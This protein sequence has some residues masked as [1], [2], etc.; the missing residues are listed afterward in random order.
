MNGRAITAEGI[1][2]RYGR[3]RVLDALDINVAQGEFVSLLGPSGSGKTTFLMVLAGFVMPEAGRLLFGSESVITK[4][5]HRRNL[6]MVF[7]SHALFPHLSVFENVAFPLRIRQ[8]GSEEIRRRVGDALALVRLEELAERRVTQLSGGQSQRVALARAIVFEPQILLMDEPLSALDKQLREHMQMEIRAL[9]EQIGLTTVYVTHDQREAFA[10]SDRVAILDRGRIVQ[11]DTP[12]RL[13]G[14]PANAFVAGFVGESSFLPVS[15][16]S[17]EPF[18]A[19]K[20]LR[21][22]RK[23]APESATL[24]MRPE[25]LILGPAT[26]A[27]DGMNH[28]PGIVER[29]VFQGDSM[30]VH[31]SLDAGVEVLVRKAIRR[32][33]SAR[34]MHAGERVD[35]CLHP[36]DVILVPGA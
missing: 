24:V 16:E 36:D 20:R 25:N 26:S 21:F 5:P 19:G 6:G 10:M 8:Q 9:H 34:T 30:I 11:I 14:T 18:V 13:Y 31:V 22:A 23:P 33:G 32:G 12:E 29:S 3:S 17:G 4:P 28:F 1:Q 35:V 27:E 7:Q 2:K 15:F